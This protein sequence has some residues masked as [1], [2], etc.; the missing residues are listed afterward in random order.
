M[1]NPLKNLTHTQKEADR[2][3]KTASPLRADCSNLNSRALHFHQMSSAPN[4]GL[5]PALWA[6]LRIRQCAGGTVYGAFRYSP[7]INRISIGKSE[8]LQSGEEAAF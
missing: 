1:D 7:E 4:A 5:K 8:F 6:S 3:V 2:T